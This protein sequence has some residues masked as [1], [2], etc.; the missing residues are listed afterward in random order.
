[1]KFN[2]PLHF[3]EFSA[4]FN[5]FIPCLKL[6]VWFLNS[7]NFQYPSKIDKELDKGIHYAVKITS[8]EERLKKKH[9]IMLW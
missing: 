1:M 7:W 8:F 4:S 3:Q 2:I 5:C 9:Y 6:V